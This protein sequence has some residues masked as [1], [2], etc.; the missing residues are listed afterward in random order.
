MPDTRTATRIDTGTGRVA[1]TLAGLRFPA[2]R[3]QL[4]AEADYYGADAITRDELAGLPAQLYQDLAT[5][6]AALAAVRLRRVDSQI[7]KRRRAPLRRWAAGHAAE[8]SS[9]HA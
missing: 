3:W 4:I 5:V 2:M 9:T 8:L 7:P 6:T 1:S